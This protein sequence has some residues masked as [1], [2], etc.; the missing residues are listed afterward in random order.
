MCVECLIFFNIYLLQS[1]RFVSIMKLIGYQN[2]NNSLSK[3]S[4]RPPMA[5]ALTQLRS[6]LRTRI[7]INAPWNM[8]SE[9]IWSPP[10]KLNMTVKILMYW[11][12]RTSPAPSRQRMRTRRNMEA[13]SAWTGCLAR[14]KSLWQYIIFPLM[15]QIK[16]WGFRATAYSSII[17]V[18]IRSST[19]KLQ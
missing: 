16:V 18:W 19:P 5:V 12:Q 10:W 3:W 7:H 15:P 1:I 11:Y 17:L 8:N 4:T 14:I 13:T 6:I 2:I 9:L